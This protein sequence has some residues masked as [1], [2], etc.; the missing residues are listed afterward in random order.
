MSI[1][2]IPSSDAKPSPVLTSRP[3]FTSTTLPSQTLSSWADDKSDIRSRIDRRGSPQL[4]HTRSSA[5]FGSEDFDWPDDAPDTMSKLESSPGDKKKSFWNWKPLRAISHI[6]RQRFYCVFSAYVHAIKGLP[7]AMNGLRLAVNMRKEETKEG[8]VQTIPSRVFQ[9][10]AEFEETLYMKC[11]VY[12]SKG[13]N[14]NSIKFMTKAFIVSVVAPDVEELDL[15]KHQLD[16]SR[17]LPE[18]VDERKGNLERG[19]SWNTSLELSGKAKGGKLIITFNYEVLDKDLAKLSGLA[20]KFQGG[21]T[22]RQSS[23]QTSYSLPNSAHGTPRTR[24]ANAFGNVSPSVSEPG[25]DFNGDLGMEVLDLDDP[26][27]GA[28]EVKGL[29]QLETQYYPSINSQLGTPAGSSHDAYNAFDNFEPRLAPS[30]PGQIARDRGDAELDEYASD[31]EQE[32]TV[33]DQGMEIDEAV[34]VFSKE[35]EVRLEPEVVGYEAESEHSKEMQEDTKTE[36]QQEDA[37]T[38]NQKSPQLSVIHEEKPVPEQA[39]A[40]MGSQ[41][42]E[43]KEPVTYQMVMKTLESLLQGTSAKERAHLEFLEGQDKL[44]LSKSDRAALSKQVKE[45]AIQA[46]TKQGVPV[47]GNDL[48]G[49]KEGGNLQAVEENLDQEVDQFLH[50]L[51]SGENLADQ[52]SDS[53]PDS[54]RAQLLKQFEQEAFLEGGFGLDLSPSKD[55]SDSVASAPGHTLKSAVGK[56]AV[57]S[58]K[59]SLGMADVEPKSVT[60]AQTFHSKIKDGREK[61]LGEL[62]QERG[63]KEKTL[64]IS[65]PKLLEPEPLGKGLGASVTVKDG[66]TLRSMDPVLFQSENCSGKLVMQVSKPVVLPSEMGSGTVDVLRNMA[67]MGI[68]N[69]ALQAMTAMPLDELMGMSIEQIAMEGLAAGKTSR[70][71]GAFGAFRLRPTVKTPVKASQQLTSDNKDGYVS[72]ENLAPMAM[73]QLEFLAMDGLRI[74]AGMTDEEAPY[75]LNAFTMEGQSGGDEASRRESTG[76]LRGVTGVH[77]LKGAKVPAQTA[78][79][80]KGLM[81]MAITLEEWM[82]LDGGSYSEAE[83]S[84]DALAIMAAHRAV[85]DAERRTV[86]PKGKGTRWGCMGNM[87]SIAMLVQL[88]DPLR[89]YEPIGVPMIAFVQAERVVMPALLKTGG[90]REAESQ[91][92]PLFKITGVHLAGVKASQENRRPGWGSQRQIRAATRWLLA[93]GMSKPKGV[94]TSRA[95][96]RQGDCLWSI[97]AQLLGSANKWKDLRKRNPHMRNPDVLY[98]SHGAVSK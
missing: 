32:F 67:S 42:D 62:E 91:P 60:T 46:R 51:E 11:T 96:L 25:N 8:A 85:Q 20:S 49:S 80:G 47:K 72:L 29:P 39:N 69:M 93:N 59:S 31:N 30:T 81:D 98:E 17:L 61:P 1:P 84:K 28:G 13:G 43:K 53:E 65:T 75:A 38:E 23:M 55:P 36:N 86:D 73:Q 92:E 16:L 33:V 90:S 83:N 76:S 22:R 6:G 48:K 68:E 78:G 56:S 41:D 63:W 52:N 64:P 12:G 54:P 45:A 89:S 79:G 58:S 40:T 9:G 19:N 37:K 24:P 21:S 71:R 5:E 7:P 3:R 94:S 27:E 88:R 77:L 57:T 34:K 44:E 14:S 82:L 10:V 4:Q 15:G 18:N 50:M 97:S 70:I 26:L 74:Q 66:G 87:L 2:Q 35:E 95:K